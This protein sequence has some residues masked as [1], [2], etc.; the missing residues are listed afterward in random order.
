[1]YRPYTNGRTPWYSV[2]PRAPA[3][4]HP[5]GY[6]VPNF[7]VD[8]DILDSKNH[9]HVTEKKLKHSLDPVEL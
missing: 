8:N 2:P 9:L 6:F 7:G 5:I 3:I 4:G 1:M